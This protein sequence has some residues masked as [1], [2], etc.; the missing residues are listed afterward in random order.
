MSDP[1]TKT[2]QRLKEIEPSEEFKQRSLSLILDSSQKSSA[3]ILF[4]DVFK[5]FQFSGALIM[6]SVLIFIVLGGLSVLNLK[7]FSPATLAGLNTTN[8]KEEISNVDLQI[9]LSEIKYYED[10]SNKTG[11]ALKAALAPLDHLDSSGIEQEAQN[12]NDLDSKNNS[13]E[14]LLNELVL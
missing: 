5:A 7:V 13:V 4:K 10:S 9:R 1:I 12:L 2:L 6:A 8:L 11:V 14:D 3:A